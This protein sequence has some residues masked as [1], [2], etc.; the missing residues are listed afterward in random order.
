[1]WT[2]RGMRSKVIFEKWIPPSQ[3]HATFPLIRA[4]ILG[5]QMF[6]LWESYETQKQSLCG[7]NAD[8]LKVK[9][10]SARSN[11]YALEA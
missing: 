2:F 3:K 11:H 8:I 6:L 1:M 5:N 4:K 7:Q 10:R 9:L